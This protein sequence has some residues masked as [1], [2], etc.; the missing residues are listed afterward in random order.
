MLNNVLKRD[1]ASDID[2]PG[3]LMNNLLKTIFGFEKY[4]LRYFSLPFGI[5]VLAVVRK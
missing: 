5:S 3:S 2:M 1:G 4:L